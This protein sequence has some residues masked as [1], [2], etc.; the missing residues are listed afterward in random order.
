MTRQDGDHRVACATLTYLAEPADPVL[1]HLLQVLSPVEVLA[2]IESGT[3]PAR[4]AR[5][6]DQAQ[7]SGLQPALARWQSQLPR[8][9]A[10]TALA[11]HAADGIRLVCPGEPGWPAQLDDLGTV[12]PLHA[13]GTRC[14]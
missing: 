8:V 5:A 11:R 4:A 14:R 1:G 7:G 10:D 6:M 9:P 13:V 3:V 12:R 2:S